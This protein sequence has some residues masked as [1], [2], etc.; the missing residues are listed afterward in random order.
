MNKNVLWVLDTGKSRVVQIHTSLAYSKSVNFIRMNRV[1]IQRTI[2]PNNGIFHYP[3][4]SCYK[5]KPDIVPYNS[6]AL[7][8]RIRRKNI[9]HI[10]W[11]A[12][13]YSWRIYFCCFSIII[14]VRKI[15]EGWLSLIPLISL[16]Q[17]PYPSQ[18]LMR[19][20]QG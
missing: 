9:N 2:D 17:F 14:H 15:L 1:L 20:R 10:R 11:I 4:V 6:R 19:G 3:S 12:F 18:P 13:N 7:F 8:S 5:L 16:N